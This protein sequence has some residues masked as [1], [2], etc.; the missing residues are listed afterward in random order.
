MNVVALNGSPR[1]KNSN[2]WKITEAFLEGL[3]SAGEHTIT[4]VDVY[5]QKIEE[6]HGCFACWKD[7]PGVCIIMDDMQDLLPRI[8]EADLVIW[9]FPLYYY[10]IPSK[11]KA[12]MDRLLP[13]NLPFMEET[14]DGSITHPRRFDLSHQHTVLISTCGFASTKNN[15]EAIEAQ[16]AIAFGK[17]RLSKIICPEGELFSIPELRTRTNEYLSLVRRAGSEYAER[18][19]ISEALQAELEP[20]I[21]PAETYNKLADASWGIPGS[22]TKTDTGTGE[23]YSTN[24]PDPGATGDPSA[25]LVRQM[26]ALY[27]PAKLGGKEALLELNFTDLGV[28]HRLFLGARECTVLDGEAPIPASVSALNSTRVETPFTV[29]KQISQGELDGARAMME[30]KYKVLGN[31]DLMLKMDG[32]FSGPGSSPSTTERPPA[33]SRDNTA[34]KPTMAL[35]ILPWMPLWIAL[36]IS[37]IAAVYAALATLA[38][39]QLAGFKWVHGRH[40]RITFA[41]V[42]A[43]AAAAAAGISAEILLPLTYLAFGVHWLISCLGPVPLTADY[44][45]DAY[46]GDEALG[47]A[48]FVK[49]N[50]IIT[51]VWGVFYLATAGWTIFLLATPLAPWSGAVNSA[52]PLLCGIWTAW[53]QKWYPARVARG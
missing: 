2:T 1:G 31:F 43:F 35:V 8:I 33:A 5:K 20:L 46:G 12:F 28:T 29:W 49:T 25:V 6:C 48:L 7:T 18:L 26:A 41:L 13:L 36:P 47:N 51:A 14:S 34:K 10:S 53:F 15:Y 17:D 21:L 30:G 45:K 50:R 4:R 42:T 16:F 23:G 22:G 40:E 9:S 37:P 27:S 38:L 44:S 3:E 11:L 19:G 52:A 39:C 32:L 24:V